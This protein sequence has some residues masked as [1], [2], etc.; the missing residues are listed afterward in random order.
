M[1]DT[2]SYKVISTIDLGSKASLSQSIAIT[3]DGRT[4]FLPQTFVNDTNRNLQFDTTVFPSIS[5][6]D[7]EK[8]VNLR[9][10]RLGLDIFDEPVGIP[11]EAILFDESL[12]ILNAASNDL[13][14]LDINTFSGSGH[15]E[16]GSHPLGITINSTGTKLYVDNSLDGTISVIDTH[17]KE[18]TSVIEVTEIPLEPDLLAGKRLFNSS[19]AVSYTHLTLPT[20]A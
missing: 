17:S 13:S 19:D 8:R 7:L 20:K 12:Y 5:I 18:E 16:L 14:I 1:V 2:Q 10:K 9:K 11:I 15:I 4:A 6:V 3:E